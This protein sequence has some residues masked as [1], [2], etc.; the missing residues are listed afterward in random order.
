LI[1]VWGKRNASFFD[2]FNQTIKDKS[3]QGQKEIPIQPPPQALCIEV[4]I[5]R[6]SSLAAFILDL[7]FQPCF[8]G[9]F[10]LCA[11]QEA[12]ISLK[13]LNPPEIDNVIYFQRSL[14]PSPPGG[15]HPQE[16]FI[17]RPPQPPQPVVRKPT[18]FSA[19]PAEA[20]KKGRG[21]FGGDQR[22]GA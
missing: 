11:E 8:P 16:N 5:Y 18:F 4:G 13:I 21:I 10:H 9:H 19:H 6:K 12:S 3:V 17:N 15:S 1:F 2:L 14:A 20:L 7:K 22:V